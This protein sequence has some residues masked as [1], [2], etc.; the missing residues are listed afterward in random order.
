M[1]ARTRRE[2]AYQAN[3]Y[4][5]HLSRKRADASRAIGVPWPNPAAANE[6]LAT[7]RW[8][9]RPSILE[10]DRI[11]EAHEVRAHV[12]REQHASRMPQ[13]R[14]LSRAM[15]RSM[16]NFEAAG[17]WQCFARRQRL[18][19]GDRLHSLLGTEEQPA[20]HLPQ[21]TRCGCHRPKRTTTLS[22][23][24]IDRVHVGPRTGFPHDRRGAADMIR[25]AVSENEVLEPMRRMA[26]P[27]HR[28]EDGRLLAWEPRRR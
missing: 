2:Q 20:Q 13:Q 25:V 12:A 22:N 11:T 8:L 10:A 9:A 28:P 4:L 18:V 3:D 7:L 21:Q 26:K 15:R 27:A 16:N 23:R 24:D 5:P 14:D 6:R 1:L 19:D 17:D